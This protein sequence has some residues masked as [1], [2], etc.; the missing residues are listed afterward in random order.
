M[1]T[2]THTLEEI[3]V[4][5]GIRKKNPKLKT[6]N[7]PPKKKIV[8]SEDIIKIFEYSAKKN[9]TNVVAAYSTL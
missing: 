9:S 2:T 5:P 1:K 3:H 8:M 7:Q 6:G 4:H